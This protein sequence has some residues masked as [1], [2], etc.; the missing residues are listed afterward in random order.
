MILPLLLTLAQAAAGPTTYFIGGAPTVAFDIDAPLD[1]INGRTRAVR[2][3][4]KVDLDQ[5]TQGTAKIDVSLGGFRTGIALRDEDLRDQFFETDKFPTA[6]LTVA[7]FEQASVDKLAPGVEAEAIAIATLELRSLKQTLRIPV[8]VRADDDDGTSTVRVTGTFPVELMAF[9][10]K[11]P[12]R[13]FLKLGPTANVTFDATFYA[14]P[15]EEDVEAT[16]AAAPAEAP[17]VATRPPEKQKPRPPKWA[18]AATTPEGRGERALADPKIGGAGNGVACTSCHGTKDE[19]QGLVDK[20][21]AVPASHSLWN[22]ARRPTLWQGFAKDAGQ[23]ASLCAKMFMLR[24]DDLPKEV[25]G[26]VRAYLEKVSPDEAPSF[27]YALLRAAKRTTIADASGGDAARGAKLTKQHCA[28]CH[29]E[30][31]MRP[32]LTPGLYEAD[33]LVR[34]VRR[35][36]GSDALQM[37]LFYPTRLTDSELRDVVAYLTDPKQRIFTRKRASPP[38]TSP[39]P[40]PPK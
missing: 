6:T 31:G 34:R 21:G 23:A 32:P 19:R 8:K 22:S 40:A 26:D 18:F 37:P 15:K 35:A 9:G 2:G 14:F 11:R 5:W 25:E 3:S 33:D 24:K 30:G 12:Q 17:V 29:G 27:D 13:L 4:G 36:P 1:T 20:D 28:R 7:K 39:A 38:P 10:M 16:V